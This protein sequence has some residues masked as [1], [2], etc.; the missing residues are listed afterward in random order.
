MYFFLGCERQDL[1]ATTSSDLLYS[2]STTHLHMRYTLP[3]GNLITLA[4]VAVQYYMLYMFTM[5]AHSRLK[6]AQLHFLK[7]LGS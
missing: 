6:S 1:R 2:A 3:A 4:A 5:N 7:T